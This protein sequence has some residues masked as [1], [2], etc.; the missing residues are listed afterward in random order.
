MSTTIN[1]I[2]NADADKGIWMSNFNTKIPGYAGILTITAAEV[3]SV[4]QDT[5]L[6]QYVLN[7]GEVYKQTVNNI[8]A[9]KKLMKNANGQQHLGA[10]PTLPALPAAPALVPEGILIG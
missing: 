1:Y 3:L 6:F 5:E 2:P 9:Y 7:I 8:T 10:I 4:Q